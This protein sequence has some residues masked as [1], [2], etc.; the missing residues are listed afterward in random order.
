[1]R[2]LGEPLHPQ[3]EF[4]C[5][6]WTKAHLRVTLYFEIMGIYSASLVLKQD[7]FCVRCVS[8]QASLV[9][10][11]LN[12]MSRVN[13]GNPRCIPLQKERLMQHK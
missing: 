3:T 9:T 5:N 13:T 12:S 2:P 11:F 1:M 8:F 6:F 7:F 10:T 4:L